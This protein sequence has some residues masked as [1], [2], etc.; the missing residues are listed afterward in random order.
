MAFSV[1]YKGGAEPSIEYL[2]EFEGKELKNKKEDDKCS[3]IKIKPTSAGLKIYNNP[4]DEDEDMLEDDLLGNYVCVTPKVSVKQ[5]SIL[6]FEFVGFFFTFLQ[7][8][9]LESWKVW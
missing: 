7:I 8:H 5:F 2:K 6:Y 1:S 3:Q 4:H 9:K